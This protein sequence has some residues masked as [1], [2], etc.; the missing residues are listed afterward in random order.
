MAEIVCRNHLPIWISGVSFCSLDTNS[1]LGPLV[2]VVSGLLGKLGL[3][4]SGTAHEQKHQGVGTGVPAI[5]L[6]TDLAR[7]R[8]NGVLLSHKGLQPNTESAK[9]ELGAKLFRWRNKIGGKN[10][11]KHQR[12][13]KR[14]QVWHHFEH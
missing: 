3:A 5:F 9:L 13:T 12:F 6:A 11:S 2:H 4:D 7:H 1:V 8:E 14:F 10:R